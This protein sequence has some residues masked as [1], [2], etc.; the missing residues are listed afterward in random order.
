MSGLGVS[1]RA[2]AAPRASTVRRESFLAGWPAS[3][4]GFRRWMPATPPCRRIDR[5]VR[6]PP[7]IAMRSQPL[8]R[9]SSPTIASA[10]VP[11]ATLPPAP[12]PLSWRRS[13]P[14]AGCAVVRWCCC[15]RDRGGHASTRSPSPPDARAGDWA[16]SCSARPKRRPARAA[17]DSSGSR[18]A[19][20]HRPC[21]PSTAATAIGPMPA[22]QAIMRT[23]RRLC[24]WKNRCRRPRLRSLAAKM[25]VRQDHP[26]A[27]E[28]GR[29]EPLDNRAGS[30]IVRTS[31]AAIPARAARPAPPGVMVR[32]CPRR[33]GC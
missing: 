13:A 23:A 18:F 20:M 28:R 27:V 12:T 1:H 19:A 10:A 11:S 26:Q 17:P 15:A 30:V 22:D 31:R 4:M 33:C 32:R 8:R 9:A 14:A 2:A 25:P 16:A 24:A 21:R 3:A 7:P 5:S 29:R 6:R